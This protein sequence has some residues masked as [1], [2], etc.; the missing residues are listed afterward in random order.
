MLVVAHYLTNLVGFSV[1]LPRWFE[2]GVKFSGCPIRYLWF[3]HNVYLALLLYFFY[4]IVGR[5]A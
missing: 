1:E 5:H 4:S 2:P 3:D